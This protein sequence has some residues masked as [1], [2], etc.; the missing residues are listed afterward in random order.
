ME[1][2]E[3]RRLLCVGALLALTGL[4]TVSGQVMPTAAEVGRPPAEAIDFVDSAGRHLTVARRIDRI[5]AAGP[6]AAIMLYT[7]APGKLLGWNRKPRQAELDFIPEPYRNLPELGRLTGRG[8]TANVEIVLQA[9]PDVI[10]DYGSTLGTY[11]SLADRVREQTGIPYALLDGAFDKIPQT[12]RLLGRLIDQ[13]P[14]AEQLAAYAQRILVEVD[15]VLARVPPDRRPRV[16][17]GRGPEGLETGLG[18]SINVEILERVGAVNV[19]AENAVRGGLA[20]VSMEQII[21]WNPEIVLT[22]NSNFFTSIK[23]N[24]LWREI[25]AIRNDRVYLAPRVPFGWF[26]RPPSVNRLIG[27]KWLLSVLYPEAVTFDLRNETRAF[28]RLFYHLDL[29]EPQLDALLEHA[30][31]VKK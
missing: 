24:P 14:R 19:A 12:Y 6:P 15:T 3:F 2:A 17:Y 22:L 10:I 28:Y 26:D 29:S 16:Y 4:G 23:T 31:N 9:K 27:V 20:T 8:N 11:V 13:S 21:K 5:Y 1:T 7:L 30:V 25:D 18:G